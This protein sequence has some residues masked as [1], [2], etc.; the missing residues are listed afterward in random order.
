MPNEY[1]EIFKDA[2]VLAQSVTKSDTL[3]LSLRQSHQKVGRAFAG[4]RSESGGAIENRV[5]ANE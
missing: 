1:A 3:S 2:I 5:V 4:Y